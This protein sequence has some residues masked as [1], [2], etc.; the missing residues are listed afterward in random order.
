MGCQRA[1]RLL[2]R[3]L[4]CGLD[5]EKIGEA[6]TTLHAFSD[7]AGNKACNDILEASVR[8]DGFSSNIE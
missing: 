7:S 3:Q 6:T 2:N 8:L 1:R 4:F 5:L